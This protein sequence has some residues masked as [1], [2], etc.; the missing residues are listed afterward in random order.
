MRR[1]ILLEKGNLE[2]RHVHNPWAS[3]REQSEM[4]NRYFLMHR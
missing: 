2:L 1:H 4:F 3:F